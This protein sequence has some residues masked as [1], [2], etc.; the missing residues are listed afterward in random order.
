MKIIQAHLEHLDA[1]SWLFDNYC[2]FYQQPSDLNAAKTF[3]R[4]RLQNSD[5]AIFVAVEDALQIVGFTQLYP[6][7]SSVSM[8]RIWILN[9]LFVEQP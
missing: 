9:D 7:F 8:E 5:S 6:S 2:V 1:V 3:L 4:D